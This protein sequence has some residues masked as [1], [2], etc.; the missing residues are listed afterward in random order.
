LAEKIRADLIRNTPSSLSLSLR[1]DPLYEALKKHVPKLRV[2][3]NIER[4]GT[5]EVEFREVATNL[6]QRIAA[7]AGE[8]LSLPV[9]VEPGKSGLDEDFVKAML[10][11]LVNKASRGQGLDDQAYKTV[12]TDSGIRL[13]RGVFL[14]ALA[15]KVRVKKIQT[16]FDRMMVEALAWEEYLHMSGIVSEFY[17]ILSKVKDELTKI[18][19]TRVVPGRCDYCPI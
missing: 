19:L 1:D 3:K 6:R 4:L 8:S 2:W 13:E 16:T 17:Q 9:G 5:M 7:E 15:P 11:H 18:I 12:P 10:S 14:I